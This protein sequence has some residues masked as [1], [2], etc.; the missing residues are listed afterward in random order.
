MGTP[1]PMFSLL[2]TFSEDEVV[3]AEINLKWINFD[4][5]CKNFNTYIKRIVLA[6]VYLE[7]LTL[8]IDCVL[9]FVI[10]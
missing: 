6:Y 7:Q 3:N 1:Y 4:L 5:D 2:K 8:V 10:L 9:C